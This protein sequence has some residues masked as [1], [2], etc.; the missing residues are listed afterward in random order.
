[1][2]LPGWWDWE[3]ELTAHSEERLAERGLS[4]IDLRTILDKSPKSIESDP[5]PGRYR[6]FTSYRRQ[7]WIV[8][9]EPDGE[10]EALVIISVFLEDLS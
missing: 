8:I 1:M 9:V 7:S 3:I 4:E 10:V 6:V 5:E 2:S